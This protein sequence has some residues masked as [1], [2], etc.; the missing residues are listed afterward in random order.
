MYHS[1]LHF[2]NS[3]NHTQTCNTVPVISIIHRHRSSVNLRGKTFLPENI[4]MKNWQN[5]QIVHNICPQFFSDFFRGALPLPP[6]P[7]STLQSK[8]VRKLLQRSQKN[9]SP[10]FVQTLKHFYRTYKQRPNSGVFQDSKKTRY[11]GLS[12]IHSGHKHGY[13]R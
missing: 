11:K 13:M 12:R 8:L 2:V 10:G 3:H 5:A 9:V 1:L 7:T 6:S 4:C